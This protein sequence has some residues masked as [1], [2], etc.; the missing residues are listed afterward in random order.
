MRWL[1][2]PSGL[3]SP[4]S[5]SLRTTVISETQ[6]L[7]LD[8]AVDEAIGFEPDAELEVLVGGRHGLEVVGAIDHGGAVEAGAVIAERLGHVGECRASP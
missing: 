2:M 4:C 3:F 7:A 1:R 5:N 8:E 6:V